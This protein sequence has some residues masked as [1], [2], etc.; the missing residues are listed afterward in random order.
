MAEIAEAK[1]PIIESKNSK[2]YNIDGFASKM[3]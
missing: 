3:I 2:I 1:G